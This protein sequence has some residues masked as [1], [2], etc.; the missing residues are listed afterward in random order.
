MSSVLVFLFVFSFVFFYM[1]LLN[2]NVQFKIRTIATC[3]V[4][5]AQPWQAKVYLALL[6]SPSPTTMSTN[7][8]Y[9]CD[10]IP[11]PR[12]ANDAQVPSEPVFDDPEPAPMQSDPQQPPPRKLCVRHQRMADEG[13]NLKLQQVY[14][15]L[16]Y[17][18]SF[19]D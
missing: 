17:I 14:I 3:G 7:A 6:L 5:R 9:V 16:F 12:L 11:A 8:S 13:T 19:S 18:F 1:Y 2:C 4:N 10:T 15:S